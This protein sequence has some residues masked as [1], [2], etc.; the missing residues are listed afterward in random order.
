MFALS[1]IFWL[2][3][4][5]DMVLLALVIAGL[6]LARLRRSRTGWRLAATGT[7]LMLAIAVIPTDPW[8]L[9]PLENRFPPSHQLLSRVD[10]IIV[11][12]GAVDPEQTERHNIPSLNEHAER[13]TS[14]IKLARLYPAAKLVFTGGSASIFAGHPKEAQTAKMLFD[15][16]GMDTSKIIF[17][18][19]SRNTYENALFSKALAKPDS[20]ENWILITSASHMPRAV[21]VF[22]RVG[23]PVLPYPVAYKTSPEYDIGLATHLGSLDRALHEWL[24]L[25]VYRLLGRTDALF[26]HPDEVGVPS[27]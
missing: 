27:H 21:G 6:L 22:R 15:D 12:G 24:G 14:F 26:P 13:M 19:A 3:I 8:L 2:F 23:W 16:L 11:L 4:E 9:A 17:E 20:G 1:K 10:G 25:L 7:I 5:P 18:D